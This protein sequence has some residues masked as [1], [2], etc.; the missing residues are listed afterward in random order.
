MIKIISKQK[1]KMM[2]TMSVFP[3]TLPSPDIFEEYARTVNRIPMLGEQEE[4]TLLKNWHDD[5]DQ[6]AAK[7]IILAHLKLVVKVVRAHKGYGMNLGDLVQEGTVGLMKAV[8]NFKPVFRVRLGAYALKWI[9][10]EVRA[11]ILVN[12]K[13]VKIGGS[14]ALKKLFF[15]YRKVVKYLEDTGAEVS[16]QSVA[17]AIG[18]SELN[19]S[20]AEGYF[21]NG[22]V[23]VDQEETEMRLLIE[24]REVV[25]EDE[26]RSILCQ[27]PSH[28][29]E[30][31]EWQKKTHKQLHDAMKLLSVRTQEIVK[32]R[33]LST[34]PVGLAVLA[35][36]Y[37]VSMERIRQIEGQALLALRKE[38]V[39]DS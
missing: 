19:V 6:S 33:W 26:E 32:A 3:S 25:P 11:F 31:D 5:A 29:V 24:Q 8:K 39:E 20:I 1:G 16:I 10:A 4:Y 35:K 30:Q 34:P 27:D 36:Q 17:K 18:V 38:M 28:V 23:S 7:K 9:E 21:A 37:G 14:A 2:T 12:W 15:G 13:L 22:D